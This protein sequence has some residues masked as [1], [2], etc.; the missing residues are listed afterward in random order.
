M[1]Q[2]YHDNIKKSIT[3]TKLGVIQITH[4]NFE[5]LVLR[6]EDVWIILFITKECRL[7]MGQKLKDIWGDVS[8]RLQGIISVGV[9]LIDNN[10]LDIIMKKY[11]I[12]EFPAIRL[13]EGVHQ[14]D[15]DILE[16]DCVYDH[17]INGNISL[18]NEK[19][20]LKD[21]TGYYCSS[22]L[23]SLPTID[24]RRISYVSYPMTLRY[25]PGSPTSSGPVAL[26]LVAEEVVKFVRMK[27]RDE[28]WRVGSLTVCGAS[29]NRLLQRAEK[30][31]R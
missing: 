26:D 21:E 7:C 18:Y 4:S 30:H 25:L 14:N 8:N 12:A 5:S 6:R 15:H 24:A 17:I 27:L 19:E 29:E 13:F 9:Y 22:Q 11:D 10:K 3:A 20:Y 31:L 2:Q 1:T 23:Y 28:Q 16:N